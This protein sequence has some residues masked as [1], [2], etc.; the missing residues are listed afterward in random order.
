MVSLL[1]LYEDVDHSRAV[2]EYSFLM[3]SI[4]GPSNLLRQQSCKSRL[5][6]VKEVDQDVK[7]ECGFES[8]HV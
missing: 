8:N 5:R 4:V 3:Y 6:A 1:Y 7:C 2:P